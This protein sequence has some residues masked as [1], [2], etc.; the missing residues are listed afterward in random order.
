M[1]IN[2]DSRIVEVFS[3]DMLNTNKVEKSE[4]KDA[5]DYIKE[6]ASNPSPDNRYEIAQIMSYV[7]TEGLAERMNYIDLIGDVKRTEIGEKARFKTE[8]D[9]LKAFWQAKSS[10]TERSKV[11]SKYVQLDTDEVSIRPVVNFLELQTGK[12]DMARLAEQAAAKMELAIIKRVQNAIYAAFQGTN[13]VNYASGAGIAK[14]AFD[15]ILFAMNR[16][17]GAVSI[18]GDV[19]AL[20][21][22]TALSGFDGN[23]PDDYVVQHNENGMIGKY[24]GSS[25]VKL[26][27]PFEAGSLTETTLR[28]DLI[29]V[30]PNVEEGLKPVKIQFEG[31]VQSIDAPVNIDS[32]EVEFKFDQYIGAGVI[33]ARKLLGVYED[34]S[35]G[36]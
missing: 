21:K 36:N 1:N 19:E 8:I 33:G 26:N 16:A 23:I 4:I 15:P 3:A 13:G 25:L 29:Y 34:T 2:K 6:L 31:G 10:T 20:S 7:I 28:K 12:V 14:Q 17:G 32:K 18:V 5:N 35:L 30:I 11:S 9:G 24:N 27:N 22:F